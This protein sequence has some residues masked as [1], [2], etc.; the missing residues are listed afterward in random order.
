MVATTRALQV[1][2]RSYPVV[3][4]SIRDPRLHLASV[5]ISIHILGQLGLGFNVSIPQ[6][7]VAIFTAAILEVILT[8]ALAGS[9]IWPASAMLTGSGVALILRDVGTVHGE[10]WSWRS[11]YVFALVAAGYALRATVLLVRGRIATLNHDFHPKS[12]KEELKEEL[13]D[14]AQRQA[15]E[16]GKP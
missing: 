2:E 5:I 9:L 8:F 12:A 13:D 1:G 4:P 14:L 6:I 3:L 16:G 11:W 15:A 7:L 10:Y